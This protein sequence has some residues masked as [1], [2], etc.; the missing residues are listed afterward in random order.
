M[1]DYTIA[2]TDED[3]R[4]IIELQK[5]NLPQSLTEEQKNSQGFVT[6]VHSFETLKKMNDIE[7]SLVAKD[8]EK[9]IGYLLAMTD[10]S[11]NDIPVLLPMFNVFDEVIYCGQKIS[12]FN[13]IVVGQVCIVDGY[14]GKGILDDCYNAYK[15]HF[16]NKYDF[17]ITEIHKTN[18]RSIRAH[19]R[20]GF[21]LIHRYK[22]P[23]GDEW[24]IVI[25][26]WRKN[27]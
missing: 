9:V 18:L 10:E 25:L 20:I 24:E 3:I 11:T 27:Q 14:R 7:A 1:I 19:L 21:E 5:L 23:N 22:D 2:K 16:K 26:D 15:R 4:Q 13:Y 8:D 6:V 17:A 12:S